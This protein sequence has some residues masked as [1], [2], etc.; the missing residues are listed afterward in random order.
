MM[1]PSL[2]C[3]SVWF[4]CQSIPAFVFCQSLHS[5]VPTYDI[6]VDMNGL[7]RLKAKDNHRNFPFESVQNLNRYRIGI[8]SIK[9]SGDFQSPELLDMRL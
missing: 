3:M 6:L 4:V 2:I 1:A 9:V 7:F 8:M 5:P